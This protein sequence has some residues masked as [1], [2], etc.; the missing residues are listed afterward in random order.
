LNKKLKGSLAARFL[1]CRCCGSGKNKQVRVR[2]MNISYLYDPVKVMDALNSIDSIFKYKI[3]ESGLVKMF[4]DRLQD[5]FNKIFLV[6]VVSLVACFVQ[7]MVFF[8]NELLFKEYQ[9]DVFKFNNIN[10]ISCWVLIIFYAYQL[11]DMGRQLYNYW[12]NLERISFLRYLEFGGIILTNLCLW[13][14]LL[15]INWLVEGKLLLPIPAVAIFLLWFRII[16]LCTFIKQLAFYVELVEQ[17]IFEVGYFLVLFIIMLLP[18]ANGLYILNRFRE[19]EDEEESI[20]G[21][22]TNITY[23]DTIFH[24]YFVTLGELGSDNFNLKGNVNEQTVLWSFLFISTLISQITMLNMMVTIMGETFGEM[25]PVKE[26]VVIYT[27]MRL[28]FDHLNLRE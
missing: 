17:T 18:F 8:S 9:D 26:S 7:A 13:D 19:A 21:I 24:Q 16:L 11:Y 2:A 3:C 10:S 5:E 20:V 22:F 12:N 4:Y 27:R 15:S 1:K 28:M 25:N 6:V 14:Y 23:V